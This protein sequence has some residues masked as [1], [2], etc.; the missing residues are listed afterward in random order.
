MAP[1]REFSDVKKWEDTFLTVRPRYQF[2]ILHADS[3]AGKT[4][5]AESRFQ[6]PFVVTV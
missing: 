5:F 2:L 3:K 1:F 6:N 4:S